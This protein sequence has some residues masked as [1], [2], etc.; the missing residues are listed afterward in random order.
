MEKAY[1]KFIKHSKVLE[2]F[3]EKTLT[4]KS[5]YSKF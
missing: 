5:K 1:D 3:F 2:Y 4:N